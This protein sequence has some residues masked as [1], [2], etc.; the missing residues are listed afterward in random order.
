MSDERRKAVIGADLV[1]QGELRN[2]SEVEVLGCVRGSISADRLVIHP[3]GRVVGTVNTGSADVHGVLDG[4]I[5]VRDLISIGAGGAVHGDVRY[6]QLALAPGGDLAAEV[7]NVP[8]EIG[9]DFELL[10]RRG[11]SV[12]LTEADLLATDAEDGAASLVYHVSG[13]LNGCLVNGAAPAVPLE[14]F[15]QL[16]ISTGNIFFR[17]DG[18]AAS[19]AGFDVVVEDSAGGNSGTPRRVTV[20]VLP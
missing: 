4:R 1:V 20:V 19:D 13:A 18:A 17:H 2:A 12:R 5:R 7:R 11:Y 9:G 10:V 14:S 6:G 16:D 3:G 8:P 15:T